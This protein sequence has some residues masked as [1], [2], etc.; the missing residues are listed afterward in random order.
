MEQTLRAQA[1]QNLQ[2]HQY[3]NATF[4]CECLHAQNRSEAN[5][6]LL[7]RCYWHSAAHLKG[8]AALQGASSGANRYLFALC[9]LELGKLHEAEAAL[10]KGTA[11]SGRKPA[12]CAAEVLGQGVG[13]DGTCPV[14]G[15]AAGLVLLGK[16]CRRGNRTAQA[17][18]YFELALRLDPFQWV[19]YAALCELGAN[20]GAEEC[21]GGAP[22]G[23]LPPLSMAARMGGSS[24]SSSSR[25]SGA[26]AAGGML[27]RGGRAGGAVGTA[28]FQTPQLGG[29][30]GATPLGE[31]S[32]G[33]GG[34]GASDDIASNLFAATPAVLDGGGAATTPA[35]GAPPLGGGRRGAPA[36]GRGGAAAAFG[37]F[38][39]P[40]NN[41]PMFGSAA[42][43]SAASL[44]SSGG[45]GGA[46]PAVGRLGFETPSD[47][48]GELGGAAGGGWADGTP[49]ATVGGGGGGGGGM[50]P[51]LDRRK[52]RPGATP[53]SAS[54]VAAPA[55][56]STAAMPPP[57]PLQ[58]QQQQ[59]QQLQQSP[60]LSDDASENARKIPRSGGSGGG[61]AGRGRGRA[62]HAAAPRQ[63]RSSARAAA[64]AA[65]V[66]SATPGSASATAAAAAADAEEAGA[67]EGGDEQAVRDL[68]TTLG[69]AYN[70]LC[71]FECAAA[72][73]E[74]RR[75]PPQQRASG[76]VQQQ[77]GKAHFEMAEY[78][79]AAAA[80]ERMRKHSPHRMDGIGA[81]STTLW[82]LKKSV[83]LC[84]LAQEVSSQERRSPEVWCA[85]GNCFSLQ[86]E[87]EVALK[88]FKRAIQLDPTFTYA[89]TLSGHEF[90]ANED[91]D[92]AFAMYRHAVRTDPRHHN[93][94][95]GLGQI[96][97]R[98]EKYDMA[99]A[100]F[101][102]ALS[103][104]PRSSVLRCYMGMVLAKN[105]KFT[106]SVRYL[107]T[108]IALQPNNPQAHFQKAWIHYEQDQFEV[109][110]WFCFEFC[111]GVGVGVVVVGAWT[112]VV[113]LPPPR[114]RSPPPSPP[115]TPPATL[116][117]HPAALPCSSTPPG[118]SARAPPRR[119]LRTEGARRV[120]H[121]GQG[122]QEDGP[123]E[124]SDD[125][126]HHR[127]GPA[128]EGQ[129]RGQAADR[130]AARER[131]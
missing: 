78:P 2:C 114:G 4:L 14:P 21:F 25:R 15:G 7:G 37:A 16:L 41:Q 42:P 79:E 106:D 28:L 23:E 19:A 52:T 121:D 112:T 91:F 117:R 64:A 88:F 48:E 113:S 96:Y 75:L 65:A 46:G 126:P 125:A 29:T 56:T 45:G 18:A 58:K 86:K 83:E 97:F 27:G 129:Q 34:S 35:L 76:W 110:F 13:G 108:A 103:I 66:T 111:F 8:F 128:P 80:F 104:N 82:Q 32:A 118:R 72:L 55:A 20:R 127:A 31:R 68:L 40:L 98:Q 89:Y 22:V 95:F 50:P 87:H 70:S 61:G 122:V 12:D 107:D 123:A 26:R 67:A 119:R 99:E 130:P 69:R 116:A 10:L 39:T 90:V 6:Q 85:V 120:H 49:D 33:G 60:D 24:S 11:L 5:L 93:A 17:I 1:E 94:W 59:Q 57:A 62:A 36:S 30:G 101:K 77:T 105:K 71:Q 115:L 3:D 51:P 81:Y 47:V 109:S 124:R 43:A 73:A 100:H 102:R 131:G 38:D 84:Y 54:A 92:K 44:A 63:T 9:C 53:G 74:L